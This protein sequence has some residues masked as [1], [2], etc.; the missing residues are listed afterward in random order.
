[1]KVYE[2]LNERQSNITVHK[3]K[4]LPTMKNIS[5]RK[6]GSGIDAEVYNA[7]DAN[8]VIKEYDFRHNGD[9]SNP[10]Y[11]YIDAIMSHEGNPFL[12]KIYNAKLYKTEEG[13]ERFIVQMEKL[14]QFGGE[15][16]EH[17]LPQLL[18]QMGIS[19]DDIST[20]YG[21]QGLVHARKI[22]DV[23]RS[24]SVDKEDIDARTR[25]ERGRQ[26]MNWELGRIMSTLFNTEEGRRKLMDD[27]TNPELKEAIKISHDII[28]QGSESFGIRG[29]LHENNIMIRFTSVGPQLVLVDP[30]V[31]RWA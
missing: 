13:F 8:S 25:E 19:I 4:T 14:T 27:A 6:R 22:T 7:K 15:N 26:D 12:P 16:V 18:K 3:V 31:G 5:D 21:D 2:L 17:I 30:V 11:L 28:K 23:E 10:V 1:M 24:H 9:T 29:D 20:K